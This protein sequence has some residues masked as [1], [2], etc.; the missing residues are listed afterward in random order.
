M[1]DEKAKNT[2]KKDAATEETHVQD[3]ILEMIKRSQDAT[4]KA[5]SAWSESVE[6][7]T[8]KLPDVP[9]LP[10]MDALPKPDEISEKFFGFAK[11]LMNTQQEFVKKLMDALPGHDKPNA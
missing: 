11:E 9:K 5:V 8:A 1:A 6:K 2:T 7:L 4:I 3:Q 10:M